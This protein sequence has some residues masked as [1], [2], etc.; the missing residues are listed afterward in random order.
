[1]KKYTIL[2]IAP[3]LALL[4]VG[5]SSPVAMQSTEYDDMYYS[6]SDKTEYIRPEAPAPEQQGYQADYADNESANEA[7]AEGE[8]LNP[9]Y[10]GNATGQQSY[11]DDEYY[12]GRTYDA[13]D[14]WY[15]P[16]YSFVDP[17]WGSAYV[18]RYNAFNSYSYDPFYSSYSAY[19][20]DPFYDSF[21]YDPY[22][23]RPF[24]GSG[25]SFSLGYNMGWGNGWGRRP[26]YSSWYPHNNFYNGYYG[27]LYNGYYARN[28]YAYYERPIVIGK[29]VKVQYGPRE[30]RGSV[31]TDNT[32]RVSGR[33]ARGNSISDRQQQQSAGSRNTYRSSRG[34]AAGDVVSPA[35]ETE[36][37]EALPTR[38]SRN[39]Y[40]DA[41]GSESR[42]SRRAAPAE[43]SQEQRQQAQPAQ[44]TPRPRTREYTPAPARER[45]SQPVQ[46]Q[47]PVQ[48]ETRTYET[49]PSRTYER[50]SNPAPTRSY[51]PSRSSSPSPASSG[52][53]SGGRPSR[54]RG[55]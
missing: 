45:R 53:N 54:G 49:R 5:C 23:N 43:R 27:G 46:R 42:P 30:S 37:K 38:P 15:R 22:F 35:T 24:Y 6:A 47:Q 50:E 44:Q 31:V 33:P 19:A 25:L 26:Y 10:S 51:E 12:D 14:N 20:Y 28:P 21:G 11:A 1:M 16:D 7:L 40:Y 55:N 39:S 29:P 34:N 13:R 4:A 17:Y 52:S 2:T 36:A 18:P 3:V 8:V 32:E 41:R 48:R 9:E